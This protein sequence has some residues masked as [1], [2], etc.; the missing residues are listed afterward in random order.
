MTMTDLY[1]TSVCW[2]EKRWA[3]LQANLWSSCRHTTFTFF[4]RSSFNSV[5]NKST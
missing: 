3:A 1:P 5:S 4:L 2:L